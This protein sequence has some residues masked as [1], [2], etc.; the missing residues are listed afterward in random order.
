M[1][2][3]YVDKQQ[4]NKASNISSISGKEKIVDIIS[5]DWGD[6]EVLLKEIEDSKQM[7]QSTILVKLDST[8]EIRI[9]YSWKNRIK[10]VK[11]NY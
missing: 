6:I 4:K 5:K 2:Y 11:K 10:R 8:M 9:S 1:Y 3:F 7:R